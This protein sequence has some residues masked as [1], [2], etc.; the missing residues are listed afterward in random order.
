MQRVQYFILF[1]GSCFSPVAS[2]AQKGTSDTS[3]KQVVEIISSYKP[4]LRNAVKINFSATNLNAD[5]SHVKLQY[6]IP[7]QNLFYTYQPLPV[8]PLALQMDTALELGTRNFV[9]LGFGNYSTPYAKGGFSFGDGK[10]SLIN[11]YGNYISSQGNIQYQDYSQLNLKATGSYFTPKNEIYGSAGITQ[12]TYNLYGYDHTLYKYSKDSVLQRF[13]SLTLMGGLRNTKP[14]ESGVNYDPHVQINF[15]SLQNKLT[16][17][18]VV[19]EAPAE[20]TF[21]NSFT[22]KVSAKEDATT[23][24]TQYLTQNIR[25]TNNVF[26]LAPSIEIDDDRFTLHGGITPT[27][28]N[29]QSTILPDIYIEAPVKNKIFLIQAGWVGQIIKNT[30]QNL[31]NVNPYL[32]PI[33]SELNTKEIEFYAGIKATIS[34]HFNFNAKA[35]FISYNNLPLFINDTT[36][37][38]KGFTIS[39]ASKANDLRIHADMSFISQDKFTITSGLTINGYTGIQNNSHAWGMIPIQFDASLR[40]WAYKRLLIK[41]DLN[42]FGGAPYLLKKD[43]SNTLSGGSDLSAGMEFVINKKFSAWLDL[44]NIFNNTYQRWYNYPVYGL[45]VLAGVIYKF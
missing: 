2:C 3:H 24:S 44:N 40:W 27:W 7:S 43:V 28:D 6:N 39:N 29:N 37:D 36:S 14:N 18:S 1:F 21:D 9:K 38:Y 31:T 19:V 22:L 13:S 30:Y 10:K 20:K 8:K 33:T 12:N 45:N 35:S 17:N 4:V 34:K 26:Q 23:Y 41:A 42:A 15:F 16:E 25:L 32:L 11:L 5:T